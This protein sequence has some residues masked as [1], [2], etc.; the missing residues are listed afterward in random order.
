M[1]RS[2]GFIIKAYLILWTRLTESDTVQPITHI[3]D[4]ETSE[5]YKEE[6]KKNCTIQIVPSGNHQQN[7]NLKFIQINLP[8]VAFNVNTLFPFRKEERVGEYKWYENIGIAL[9]TNAKSLSSFY[10]TAG[11]IAKQFI[12]KLQ[13]GA[14]HMVPITLSLP[15]V[16][17]FQF[18]PNVS[19][20][21]RWFQQQL[22]NSTIEK[23]ISTFKSFS[24]VEPYGRGTKS[25]VGR[26]HRS[27][28]TFITRCLLRTSSHQLWH[29]LWRNG[30]FWT[31][32]E[33]SR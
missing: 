21:E 8:D 32:S 12:D 25:S 29:E 20:Q 1:R 22:L 31:W 4:N 27:P 24:F 6:I 5:A 28:N 11:N 10:D 3:L 7:V 17:A 15:S 30:Y 9:N 19:Y 26:L 18:A 23:S 14:N 2:K 16:G 33:C 13:W